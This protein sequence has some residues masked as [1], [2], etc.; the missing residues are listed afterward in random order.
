[1]AV[2][3][4]MLD[5][6]VIE[7]LKNPLLHLIRNAAD[8]GIE[9]PAV[10]AA[11]GKAEEA[12]IRIAASP[13]GPL[14]QITI[15]DDGRGVDFERVRERV[16]QRG[17]LDEAELA[18]LS[19]RELAAFLFLAGFSTA[20]AGEVSGRGVGLDVVRETVRSLHGNVELQS[21]ASSGCAFVIT[22]PV[23]VS[24]IRIL[25]VLTGGQYFGV[26]T[27]S[28]RKTGRARLEELRELNGRP[29]LPID[30]QPVRWV[31][32]AELLD[33]KESPK[34]Q[35]QPAW[36]YL[37]VKQHDHDIAVAVE[38]MEDESEVLLKP[39]G[40]PLGGLPGVMG[41]TIRADGSLEMVLDLSSSD[42]FEND[43]RP[44]RPRA[45]QKAS[46]H[47]LVVDD[48]PTTRAVLRNVFTA[49]GYS[50]ITATD[51]VDALELLRSRPVDLVVSDVDMPRLNGFDLT[52]QIKSKFGLPT[53]L[54][55]GREKEEHRREGLAVG[56]DAFVVKSTFEDKGLLE[57]VQQ[58]L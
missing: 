28:I 53:I 27:I 15:S 38:D 56:A 43:S 33:L 51:G 58:F 54:V 34:P 44:V 3:G 8:H 5:K 57:V 16:R 45:D 12:V 41:A 13:R 22:V 10:R 46:R 23:T 26:P 18:A 20:P 31:H 17:E 11:A 30:G 29:V 1:V 32:L 36:S 49:A 9:T 39:L 14:V 21:S 35:N 24:T 4:V 55:T 6:A 48:S 7:T 2:G 40:F 19:E 52:R 25:T 47:I 50:V 42:W 37:L